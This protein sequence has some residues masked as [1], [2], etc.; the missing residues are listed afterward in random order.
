MH[1]KVSQ[2]PAVNVMLP[3]KPAP[4]SVPKSAMMSH[5]MWLTLIYGGTILLSSLLLFLVQPI[6][7]K[8]ILP[9][10]GGS[11]GVW[12]SAILFFQAF[13]LLGYAYAHFTTRYLSPRRQTWLHIILLAG[14][15]ALLP[16]AA[17][18]AFKP[19]AASQPIPRT[20]AILTVSVGFPYFLL[21]ATGP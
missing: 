5:T 19:D 12:T 21:S 2:T 4:K 9:W 18:P 14:S 1:L 7:T 16:I 20:L 3:N 6:M 8:A 13:L 11:A 10:F 15:L 17:S